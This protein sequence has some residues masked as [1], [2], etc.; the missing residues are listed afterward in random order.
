MQILIVD[1]REMVLRGIPLLLSFS[2]AWVVWRST[3]DEGEASL[4]ARKLFPN[5]SFST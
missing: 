5:S 4:K 1:D 2:T 3:S